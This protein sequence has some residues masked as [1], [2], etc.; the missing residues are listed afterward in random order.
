MKTMSGMRCMRG[1]VLLAIVAGAVAGGKVAQAQ[2][3]YTTT[4]QTGSWNTSRWNNAADSVPYTSAYTPN[5]DVNFTSTTGTSFQF[6]GMGAAINV[7]NVTVSNGVSVSF[8]ANANTFATSGN[9]RTLTIGTG[10]QLDFGSQSFTSSSSSG[11]IK[12]GA[13]VLGLIGNT[14]GGGFTLNAGTVVMRGVNALGGGAGNVLTLNGGV[15]ASSAT[16]AMDST[17]YG[18]GIVIG[19][20]VQFGEQS[21]NV[22]IASD[23][24]NLSFANDVNLGSGSRTLTLG[25]SG[26]QTFSGTISNTSGGLVFA[27]NS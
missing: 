2:T 27:A 18:G 14:Y 26:I 5:Q 3:S 16:L 15:V 25:N 1:L 8:T 19:G 9:V 17:K 22:S 11:F 23:T 12:E 21:D 10:S 6:A 7:G 24:A 4:T 13:G 20:N